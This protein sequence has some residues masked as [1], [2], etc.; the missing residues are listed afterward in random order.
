LIFNSWNG[1]YVLDRPECTMT[2]TVPDGR[3]SSMQLPILANCLEVQICGS[4]KTNI[5]ESWATLAFVLLK[6]EPWKRNQERTHNQGVD[7]F[8]ESG[9]P[10]IRFHINL[11]ESVKMLAYDRAN[12]RTCVGFFQV[13]LQCLQ[14]YSFLLCRSMH[15]ADI[16]I[17]VV[18]RVL[19]HLI[20]KT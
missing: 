19:S 11:Y 9:F 10:R 4:K 17:E 7:V 1:I 14:L 5:Q 16:I 8:E 13:L 6:C 12:I 2:T 18:S 20:L 15:T 3:F